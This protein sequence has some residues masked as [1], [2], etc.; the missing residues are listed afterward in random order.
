MRTPSGQISRSVESKTNIRGI[1]ERLALETATWKR[2]QDNPGLSVHEA[3]L[4]EHGLVIA[5]WRNDYE[6]A[7]RRNPDGLHENVFTQTHFDTAISFLELHG[8]Y[9]A[10]IE[11]GRVR[12]P[13]DLNRMG[14]KDSRDPFDRERE[15]RHHAV[16][17]LYRDCRRVILQSGALCM[18][19]IE[20]VVI[21]NKDVITML[22]ELRCALNSLGKVLRVQ[23]AA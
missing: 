4:Q 2:R 3:R 22:P 9:Q 23:R 7:R 13:S 17:T 12:S 21:E 18:M 8:D 11:A 6:K 10:V 1:E 5:R 20:T 14:G 16:E 19:A 15:K